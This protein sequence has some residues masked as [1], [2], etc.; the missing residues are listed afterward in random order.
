MKGLISNI[1]RTSIHDGFGIRTTVFFKG[2]PLNCKWCHNP[3]CI[4]PN[5][6][7]L[8]YPEKC[9]GCGKCD[10]GCYSGAK[11]ICGDEMTPEEL[12]KEIEY[13]VPYYGKEG[14]VTFSGGEPLMQRDFLRECIK[15]CKCRNIGTAV[16]T[17]LAIY[18]EDIFKSLD[19]IMADLKIWD[20]ELHRQYTGISNKVIIEN[21]IKL[22][23]LEKPIIARTPVIPEIDQKIDKISMFLRSLE[24]VIRYELLPYHSL[25]NTKRRALGMEETEF[26]IPAKDKMKELKER[27]AFIR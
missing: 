4:S 12:L 2:C 19:F 25:G 15:L 21:F 20:D 16:E 7:M 10:E 27:Y 6:E 22:N 8:Y 9:I 3:E 26:T 24:N 1:Q 14:G 18:D 5:R 11:V 17:S 13:D 23:S